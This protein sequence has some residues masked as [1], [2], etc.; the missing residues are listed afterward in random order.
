[1]GRCE[2]LEVLKQH[3]VMIPQ[4]IACRRRT[5]LHWLIMQVPL[6]VGRPVQQTGEARLS[7]RSCN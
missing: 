6:H 3:V 4:A 7:R 5:G 1:L 2:G